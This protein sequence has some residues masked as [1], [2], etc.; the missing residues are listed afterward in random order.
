[1]DKS[2]ISYEWVVNNAVD[3]TDKLAVKG[4]LKTST[5]A[6]DTLAFM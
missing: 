6:G 2:S 3:V 5:V 4:I 1:M